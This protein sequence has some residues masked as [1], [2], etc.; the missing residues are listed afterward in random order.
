MIQYV[1]LLYSVVK[2]LRENYPKAKIKID[3]KKSEKEIENGLFYV[4]VSPLDST[5]SFN[6]RKKL[7]NI[8]I[9]YIEEVKTQESSLKMHQE[10]EELFDEYI[11][12]GKRYLPIG[13]KRFI[14]N[15]DNITLQM[16]LNYYDSKGEKTQE[17]P[18]D[19]Y[20]ALMEIVKLN[21]KND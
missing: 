3:K 10:L 13:S 1:D 19:T 20:E 9:E 6:R 2:P 16:T 11:V 15:D 8:Y 18:D 4:I 7:L 17:N 12:V 5:T 14:D 21:I